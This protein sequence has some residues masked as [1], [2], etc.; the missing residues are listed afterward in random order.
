[1][2]GRET[3]NEETRHHEAP[4]QGSVASDEALSSLC[5]R[6]TEVLLPEDKFWVSG[7]LQK[8]YVPYREGRTRADFICQPPRF[9]RVPGMHQAT[10][11]C[12]ILQVRAVPNGHRMIRFVLQACA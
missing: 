12:F 6:E 8:A 3:E 5:S 11:P 9:E 7:A 2:E 10:T 4:H 1:M